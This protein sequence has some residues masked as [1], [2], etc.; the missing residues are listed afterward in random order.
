V[1]GRTLRIT[2][3]GRP[4]IDLEVER[5]SEAFNETMWRLMG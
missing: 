3:S 5:L 2:S 4:V 1:R